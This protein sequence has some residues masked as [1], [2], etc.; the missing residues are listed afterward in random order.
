VEEKTPTLEIAARLYLKEIAQ[1]ETA[2]PPEEW[3]GTIV[4]AGK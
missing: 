4:F 1:Y 2:P 3:E